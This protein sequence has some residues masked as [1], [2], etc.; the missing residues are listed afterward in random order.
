MY[1]LCPSQFR[2]KNGSLYTVTDIGHGETFLPWEGD[3]K[4][5]TEEELEVDRYVNNND[6]RRYYGFVECTNIC[7]WVKFLPHH[8]LHSESNVEV[9]MTQDGEPQFCVIKTIQAGQKLRAFYNSFSEAFKIPMVHYLRSIVHKKLVER[10]IFERPLNLILDQSKPRYASKFPAS[11][12]TFSDIIDNSS[13]SISDYSRGDSPLSDLSSDNGSL[14]DHNGSSSNVFPYLNEFTVVKPVTGQKKLLSCIDCGKKFDRPSLLE[15]HR[16]IHTGERPYSCEFC[17]KGFSTSSSLNTHRRI[18]TGE[19]PHQC[20]T[21]GKKFTA[22]SN[23]YY[24]KMTHIKDKPHKC[25]QCPRSFST[26][27][28]L[29]NHAKVHEPNCIS[30]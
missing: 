2:L 25:L 4:I 15:R 20:Q 5:M 10:S 9:N 11:V 17:N 6:I 23:L 29:R 14:S 30:L 12:T 28:D 19:K 8:I 7:N 16:R 13:E 21:C 1:F 27:G 24:H 3:T 22:S 26:P 18:H